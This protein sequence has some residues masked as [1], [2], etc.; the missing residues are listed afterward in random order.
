MKSPNAPAFRTAMGGYSKQ[1][2]NAYIAELSSHYEEK[3][4]DLE[5]QLAVYMARADEAEAVKTEAEA[6]AARADAAHKELEQA[7][8]LIAAQTEKLSE[9]DSL[10]E[11]IS[12]LKEELSCAKAALENENSA[13]ADAKAK[14]AEYDQ[15]SAKVGG[16]LLDANAAAEQ[17]RARAAADADACLEKASELL[18]GRVSQLCAE[19][20]DSMSALFN[21]LAADSDRLLKDQQ[22]AIAT[23]LGSLS[24]QLNALRSTDWAA[25]VLPAED[26]QA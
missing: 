16:I 15:V 3:L 9:M 21:R 17:I 23:L 4:T 26:K 8:A 18:K 22:F 19:S 14:L 6:A 2:V 24:V 25:S 1:D 11:E 12:R 10:R 20:A 13:S 5:G 7:N